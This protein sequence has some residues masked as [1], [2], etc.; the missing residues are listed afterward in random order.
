MIKRQFLDFLYLHP[1]KHKKLF[2]YKH[3][4]KG[5]SEFF[6]PAQL[7][8][9]IEEET[10]LGKKMLEDLKYQEKV[11]HN[12][13]MFSEESDFITMFEEALKNNDLIQKD[14]ESNV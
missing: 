7:L 1:Q 3:P 11:L 4:D 2:C 6:S 5:Y 8:K 9:E 14:P 10:E 12:F 13:N